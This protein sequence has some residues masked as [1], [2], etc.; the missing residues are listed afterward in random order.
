MWILWAG[1]T[2]LEMDVTHTHQMSGVLTRAFQLGLN[3]PENLWALV[4]IHVILCHLLYSFVSFI[5]LIFPG[6]TGSLIC[7]PGTDCSVVNNHPG[8]NCCVCGKGIT[9]S[10]PQVNFFT[11]S[12][13]IVVFYCFINR[14]SSK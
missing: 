14:C 6:L 9:L 3:G 1:R 4:L 7:P 8:D 10:I 13:F 5:V 11:S 12:F 2:H